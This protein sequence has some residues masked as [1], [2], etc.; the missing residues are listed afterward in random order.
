[1]QML[2]ATSS[3]AGATPPANLLVLSGDVPLIKPETIPAL[4]DFHLAERAAM[5]ILTAVPADPTGYGRVLRKLPR[6]PRSHRHRR[7]EGPQPATNSAPEINSGIYCFETAAL[8]A[9]LD[10]LSD[11]NATA[12]STSPTSPPCSSPTATASSPPSRPQSTRSSAP[13]PSPR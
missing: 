8:F 6:L 12:S 5:T 11:Q 7:A 2:K 9:N 4:C 1:M 13:T 10:R 3:S